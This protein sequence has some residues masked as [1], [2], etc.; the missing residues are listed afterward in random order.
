REEQCAVV[1]VLH[2]LN[3]AAQYADRMIMLHQGHIVCD[4]PP[5]Q[6]LSAEMIKQIYGHDS[7]IAPHPT[8]DFPMVYP[9]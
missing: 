7:M 1:I 9:V 3:L 8:L 2:D 6:A 4:A 5:W